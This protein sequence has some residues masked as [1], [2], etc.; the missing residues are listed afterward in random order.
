MRPRAQQPASGLPA[1][2]FDDPGLEGPTAL[3][4][5]D[6]GRVYGHA[7]T[8]G[9]CHI[10]FSGVCVEPP[11]S[12]AAYA[13]FRTGEVVCDDCDGLS[14]P[15]GTITL[16]TGHADPRASARAAAEHYDNTGTVVADVAVG[17]DEFGLWVAG[18][19]R[20]RVLDDPELLRA[21]RASS[22]SGDWRRI[23]GN[24]ELV[25]LLAVNVPG[26]PVSRLAASGNPDG[27]QVRAHVV[28]GRQTSLVASG[29]L[30]A[31]L[32][33]GRVETSADEQVLRRLAAR[34]LRAQVAPARADRIERLRARVRP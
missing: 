6:D 29:V 3:T 14:V 23:G 10:G 19:V 16:G 4:V 1:G 32:R 21:L 31:G 7:A 22:L 18:A 20:Q 26:F 28:D 17:E 15:V 2:W 24:L 12:E 30:P 13:Y 5:D 27:V 11:R 9:T 33:T 8:W 34:A 25:G